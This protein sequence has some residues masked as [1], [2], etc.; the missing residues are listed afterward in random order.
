VGPSLERSRDR[1]NTC[2]GT[3]ASRQSQRQGCAL[4]WLFANA[5]QKMRTLAISLLVLGAI[6][7]GVTMLSAIGGLEIEAFGHQVGITVSIDWRA[8]YIAAPLLIAGIALWFFA[9]RTPREKP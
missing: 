4:P 8:L 9:A 3:A 1:G 6:G 7:C 5:G 2:Q